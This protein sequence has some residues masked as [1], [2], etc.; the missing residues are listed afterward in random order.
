VSRPAGRFF[1]APK[2]PF[3]TSATDTQGVQYPLCRPPSLAPGPHLQQ[4]HQ[5]QAISFRQIRS[6]PPALA[7]SI[8]DEARQTRIVEQRADVP[9]RSLDDFCLRTR[10]PR[11]IMENLIRAEALDG[12]GPRRDLL[13]QLGGLLYREGGL[14]MAV[15]VEAAELPVLGH[16]ERLAWE[17]E[18][19][20][21][22]PGDHVMSPCRETLRERG[23]L[24]SGELPA[25]HDGE[26]VRVAG[27]AVVR[28]RPPMAEG[29]LFITLEDEESLLNLIVRPE[30]YEH[31]R[32]ALRGSLGLCRVFIGP[33]SQAPGLALSPGQQ[34]ADPRSAPAQLPFPPGSGILLPS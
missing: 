27:W 16:G 23:M 9:L 11:A 2:T 1:L 28:Q 22:A 14:G 12:L 17:Y 4:C 15:P 3:A 8:V 24:S 6:P 34:P 20:G 33:T 30:V 7:L 26:T 19:L 32:E 10:L 13:W 29:M 21:L 25:Q 18:L 31:Y 5:Q